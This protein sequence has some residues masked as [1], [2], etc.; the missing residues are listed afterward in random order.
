L[1]RE[2]GRKKTR[3]AIFKKS[4]TRIAEDKVKERRK[5]RVG[6]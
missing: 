3:E 4:T 1:R 2:K 6:K 5:G